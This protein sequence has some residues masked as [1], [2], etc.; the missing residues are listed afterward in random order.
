MSMTIS[1]KLKTDMI[2]IIGKLGQEFS[3]RQTKINFNSF[4]DNFSFHKSGR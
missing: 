3:T 2:T 1:L 4:P